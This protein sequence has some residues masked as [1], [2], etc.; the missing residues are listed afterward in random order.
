MIS[1]FYGY[2]KKK[3]NVNIKNIEKVNDDFSKFNSRNKL[4]ISLNSEHNSDNFNESPSSSFSRE[5]HSALFLKDQLTSRTNSNN[6]MQL[7]LS[8]HNENLK[9][10][11]KNENPNDYFNFDLLHWIPSYGEFKIVISELEKFPVVI[12][13]NNASNVI[14]HETDL[15]FNN[16]LGSI[17][18]YDTQTFV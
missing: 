3:F 10:S 5:T 12:N 13:S 4:E 15:C 6:I 9:K 16:N 8:S 18:N 11:F 1:I 7:S 14:Y 2:A 17:N